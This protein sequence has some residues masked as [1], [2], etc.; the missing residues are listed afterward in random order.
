MNITKRFFSILLTIA[1]SLS[2]WALETDTDGTYLIG[3]TDDWNAFAS[4]I[5]GGSI[6]LTAN[7]KLTADIA[8]ST[9]IGS[10][11]KKYAGVFDGKT[12]TLNVT[13]S[14]SSQFA[15][16]FHY[17][18]GGTI[19]NLRVEGTVSS[20]YAHMSG[21]IGRAY[22]KISIENCIVAANI[23]MTSDYA[24]GFVGNGG[25][26]AY[27]GP[28]EVVMRN[29]LFIGSFTG[30]S[31]NR[32]KA[33]AFWGWGKSTP[34]F[35]NC[36]ENGTYTNISEFSPYMFE[37]TDGENSETTTNS[38]YK[39]GSISLDGISN[40]S[41]MTDGEIVSL[42]GDGWVLDPITKQPVL[43]QFASLK[44]DTEGYYLIGT[45]QDWQVFAALVET[46]PSAN[47]KMTADIDLGDDQTMIGSGTDNERYGGNNVVYKGVF[48]G[49]GYTLTINYVSSEAFIAPIRHIYGATIKNLHVKGSIVGSESGLGGIVASIVGTGTW[50]YIQ[51]CYSSVS[52]ECTN[53]SSDTG[54]HIGGIVAQHG[55]ESNLS[56][57]DCLFDGSLK[58]AS[59]N[60][61]MSGFVG[62]YDGDLTATN[63]LQIGT[64]SDTSSSTNQTGTF[65]YRWT[66]G[67]FTPTNCYYLNLYGEAQGTQVTNE[68]LADGTIATALGNAW[69]Q[70]GST[71]MLKLFASESGITTGEAIQVTSDKKQVASEV[72]YSI[73]GQKLS[74]RPAERGIYIHNGKKIVVN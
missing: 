61:I 47:A 16:P 70:D 59:S 42:L 10:E 24:A 1:F 40:A 63:C 28:S 21:L 15:A 41:N 34:V 31:G 62:C 27:G 13:I 7:A 52:I 26:I 54:N 29:C 53:S 50:S 5:N 36:L 74:G 4:G 9:M 35:I 56:M 32:S 43:N 22:G 30:V 14:G 49:N 25:S 60:K 45:A 12:H 58:R 67:T 64:M 73:S 68:Q 48:D 11:S 23:Y 46:T 39:H 18:K 37:G 8:V 69:V 65:S 71:P 33:S 19:K 17:V 66:H 2:A 3:S 51:N 38:Y 20:S 6:A 72:W 44:Q 57:T 55:W